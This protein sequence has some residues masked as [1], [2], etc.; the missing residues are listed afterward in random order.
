M[1]EIYFKFILA[2]AIILIAAR[3]GG[4]IAKRYLKQP[5]V[6]GELLAGIIIGPFALGSLIGDPIILNFATISE[7]FGVDEFNVMEVISQ[8][9]IV[10]LLFEVGVETDVNLFLQQGKTG[11][12]AA[13]GGAV[14]P[15]VCGYFAAMLLSPTTGFVSWLFMGAVLTATSIGLSA[16]ILMDMDLLRSKVGTTILAGA[17]VDDILGVIVLSIVASIAASGAAAGI[18]DVIFTAIKIGAIGFGVWYALLQLGVKG[19]EYISK[20]L[21]GPFK[22]SETM[23]IFALLLGFLIAYLVTLAELHPVVG[24]YVAGLMFAATKE[25]GKIVDGTKPI[26]LLL[27][28][29]FFTYLGMQMNIPAM[30][31]FVIITVILVVIAIATK[32]IGCYM[33][34][35]VIGKMNHREASIVG[36]GMVPRAEVALIIAGM[37]LLSGAITRPLFGAAVA[38]SLVTTLIAPPLLK[39]LGK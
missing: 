32:I 15:F 22:G 31:G 26:A 33:P 12:A 9:A 3:I 27:G 34:A 28:P 25:K 36:V 19:R 4:E 10:T 24:A 18:G 38:V 5:P 2:F 16:R 37:G 20:F 39:R 29:F 1:G 17:V 23:P 13:I 14:L 11:S 21:L 35:R 8:I 6:I 30:S 7:A